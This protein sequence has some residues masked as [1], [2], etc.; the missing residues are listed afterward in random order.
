[1]YGCSLIVERSV[2]RKLQ[3]I[4]E[5]AAHPLVIPGLLVELELSRHTR[6][7][8]TN[9]ADVE[10]K[11]LDLN[12]QAEALSRFRPAEI[13]RRNHV[14]RS[15]WLDLTYL[16]NSLITWTS[17]LQRM[18]DHARF[19]DSDQFINTP[20]SVDVNH[21]P[22]R[23]DRKSAWYPTSQ[24]E[25]DFVFVTK[26]QEKGSATDILPQ[27]IEYSEKQCRYNDDRTSISR[28][29]SSFKSSESNASISCEISE[30]ETA[31]IYRMRNV[32]EKITSRLI[33]ICDEY[34]EKIRDC[35][36][37]VD[38]MAM[39]TQWVRLFIRLHPYAY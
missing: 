12:V 1:M 8:E 23:L 20:N 22:T 13:E 32:G 37:R 15:A 11:I 18:I 5:E 10:T 9:I 25:S 24:P 34:D 17:Q 3:T 19:L 38:G 6:L 21:S 31:Y 27:G 16:R 29:G 33:S 35:T 2:L 28:P 14:K 30:N 36:M 26:K 4:R 7:V 39:A